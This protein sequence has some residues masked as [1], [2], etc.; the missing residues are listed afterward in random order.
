M[1]NFKKAFTL[2]ELLVV[3]AIIGV[4][5]AIIVPN[6]MGARERAN[7]SKVKQDM[8]SI[9]NALRSYYNDNQSYPAVLNAVS[10]YIPSIT[11]FSPYEYTQGSGGDGFT[12][13]AAMEAT[14]VDEITRS[15]QACGMTSDTRPNYYYVCAN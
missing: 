1:K 12:L 14:I 2:I 6:F 10:S 3:I 7:D 15:K 8:V 9:K 4:L 5:T 11:D 13:G